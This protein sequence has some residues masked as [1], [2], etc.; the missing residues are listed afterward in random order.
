MTPEADIVQD[1]ACRGA[2]P[3]LLHS[4][5]AIGDAEGSSQLLRALLR[6][7]VAGVRSVLTAKIAA[8]AAEEIDRALLI[9][10]R[11]AETHPA[12]SACDDRDGLVSRSWRELHVR[13]KHRLQM[14]GA[15][16]NDADCSLLVAQQAA[17]LSHDKDDDRF[18][19]PVRELTT[20]GASIRGNRNQRW[21][22][23][24][25]MTGAIREAVVTSVTP[26]ATSA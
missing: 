12:V 11:R 6:D 3:L 17:Q 15:L 23:R 7:G 18:L 25:H 8:A 4:V 24:L 19:G 16:A 2:S 10:E 14:A 21:D 13:W 26:V 1:D 20:L 22:L 5:G 9:A